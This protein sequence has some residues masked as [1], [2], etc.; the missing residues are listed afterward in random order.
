MSR[1]RT[2]TRE[3]LS[4]EGQGAWDHIAGTRGGV[5]GPFQVFIRVPALATAVADVGTYIRFNGLLSPANRELAILTIAREIGSRFEWNGHAPIAIKEGVRPEAI[6][7]VRV[8]G[9][10]AGLNERERLIVDTARALFRNHRFSDLEY[11]RA[12]AA[13]GEERLVEL[14]GIVGFY[15]LIGFS[16]VAFDVEP[17]GDAPPPF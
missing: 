5:G 16:L 11:Q 13:L 2:V 12:F 10:T 17:A 4:A 3:E 1:L 15:S 9:S 6:E 14:V 8:Q 7:V